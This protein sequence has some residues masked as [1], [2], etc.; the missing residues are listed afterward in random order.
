MVSEPEEL[1]ALD[2][3]EAEGRVLAFEDE[4]SPAPGV[5][6][7]RVGGH[8]PGQSIVLVETAGG[9]VLLSSDA[10]HYVEELET[11]RPFVHLD[12]LPDMYAALERVRETLASGQA[13]RL[14]PGHDPG[15]FDDPAWQPVA[16][17]PQHARRLVLPT[18]EAAA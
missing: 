3:A 1:S 5:R 6:V 9:T 13:V 2:W 8:T 17:L 12:S 18:G 14:V 11:D 4:T 7:L 16:E 15:V 10:V